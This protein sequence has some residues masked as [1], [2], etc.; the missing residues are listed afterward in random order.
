MATQKQRDFMDGLARE[1]GWKTPDG[2]A[3]M[4][5][6]SRFIKERFHIDRME[7]LDAA[8]ASKVI[9]GLKA[10]KARLKEDNN[11]VHT[12]TAA[13]AGRDGQ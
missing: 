6:I 10:M 9:E 11:G 1:L 12:E 13:C 7:W 3:D 2:S 4:T 8:T 5:R